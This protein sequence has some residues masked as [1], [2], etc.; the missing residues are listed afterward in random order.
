MERKEAFFD[1]GYEFK[2]GDTVKCIYSR[3]KGR[4]GQIMTLKAGWPIM[5][6]N[7]YST[8]YGDIW[9]L[10]NKKQ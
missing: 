10:I 7:Q 5:W 3:V 2:V 4:K 6:I 8:P 1:G 9:K